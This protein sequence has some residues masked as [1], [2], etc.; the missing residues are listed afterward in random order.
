MTDRLDEALATVRLCPD[1]QSP[2]LSV[3]CPT[4]PQQPTQGGG[5]TI[6]FTG[7]WISLLIGI[8]VGMILV[9]VVWLYYYRKSSN[10]DD[11]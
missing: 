5:L 11:E 2:E 4:L 6:P 1:V 7:D 10:A 3:P 8:A 9:G